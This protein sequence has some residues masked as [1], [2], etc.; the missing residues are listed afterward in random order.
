MEAGP[1]E[2]PPHQ[3]GDAKLSREHHH[4]ENDSEVVDH[5]TDGREYE[6]AP[7]LEGGLGHGA[8]AQEHGREHQPARRAGRDIER[9]VGESGRDRAHQ[10]TGQQRADCGDDDGGGAH[11]L[12]QVC[13]KTA[14][15][16]RVATRSDLGVH[17]YDGREQRAAGQ[18]HEDRVGYAEGRVPGVGFGAD[19][20]FGVDRDLADQAEHAAGDH[21]DDDDAGRAGDAA[22]QTGAGGGGAGGH[23][24]EPPRTSRRQTTHRHVG[25]ESSPAARRDLAQAFA[26]P[27]TRV[28]ASAAAGAP[29]RNGGPRIGVDVRRYHD[30][31]LRERT[32]SDPAR[33]QRLERAGRPAP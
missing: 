6:P 14:Q 21:R 25:R 24:V 20:E 27:R 15:R 2:R 19:T 1:D 17:G 22:G 3:P 33:A 13:D 23:A 30:R 18:Q 9:L 31:L 28:E 7:R 11:D 29:N 12:E 16:A 26:V 4:P 8:E 5:R 10:R 32:R